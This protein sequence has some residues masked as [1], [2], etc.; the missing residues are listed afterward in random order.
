MHRNRMSRRGDFGPAHAIHN[1]DG[2]GRVN[3]NGYRSFWRNGK[4]VV[5][6]RLVMEEHLGRALLPTEHVHHI[7]GIRLDNRLENLELWATHHQPG[8]RVADQVRFAVNILTE[9]PDFLRA[10]GKKLTDVA[11]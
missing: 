3:A 6:H 7:N 4:Q 9:Y 2:S 1:R 10:L 11:D 5:E 8:Q